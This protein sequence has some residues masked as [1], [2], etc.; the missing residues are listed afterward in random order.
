MVV[1]GHG[2]HVLLVAEDAVNN[3]ISPFGAVNL[4]FAAVA[5]DRFNRELDAFSDVFQVIRIDGNRRSF[6]KAPQQRFVFVAV[7]VGKRQKIIPV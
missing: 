6:N 1:D 3:R 7:R 5:F 2:R 4:D